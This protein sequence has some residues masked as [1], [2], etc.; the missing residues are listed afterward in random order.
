MSNVKNYT[1][2][3]GEKTVIGGTL[4]IKQGASVTGLPSVQPP[5]ATE[6]TLGGIK[7]AAKTEAETVVAKIGED[8]KVYVPAHPVAAT[9]RQV[10]LRMSLVYLPI[11]TRCSQ[12]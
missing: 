3:G 5:A 12:K 2:Q 10:R 6:T 8:G 11:S 7:A 9:R 4:E 1:E